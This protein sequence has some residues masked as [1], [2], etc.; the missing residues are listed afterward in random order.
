[1]NSGM[2]RNWFWVEMLMRQKWRSP[3]IMEENEVFP[4]H[5]FQKPEKGATKASSH[6][7]NPC[8]QQIACV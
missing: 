2:I 7:E 5:P 4:R 1:M 8:A 3:K 6:N